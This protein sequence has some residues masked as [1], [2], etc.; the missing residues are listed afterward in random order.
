M[1]DKIAERVNKIVEEH[2]GEEPDKVTEAA[3]F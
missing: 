3:S 2:L 1:S